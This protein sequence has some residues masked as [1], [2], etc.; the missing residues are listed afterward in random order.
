MSTPR[1]WLI[2]ASNDHVQRGA[3]GGFIQAC[4]GKAAP[5]RRMKPGDYFVYYSGKMRM[6][7]PEPCQRFTA[8]GRVVGE[9]VYPFQMAP[10][11]CPFRRDVEYLPVQEASILPL[12]DRLAFIP[13]K[14]SWGYPFRFGFLELPESD[15]RE[16]ATSMQYCYA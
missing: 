3:A 16:I 1:F 11:F 8:L 14:K 10:D 4:H 7:Q 13:N 5:L 12:I 9:P 15:F 6:G 2:V